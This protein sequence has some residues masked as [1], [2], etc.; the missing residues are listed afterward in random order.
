MKDFSFSSLSKIYL[1]EQNSALFIRTLRMKRQD[2][3]SSTSTKLC[4]MYFIVAQAFL[5]NT[6][7][8]EVAS[9]Y[10]CIRRILILN[11]RSFTNL[12]ACL[13]TLTEIESILVI[14]L[15]FFISSNCYNIE[16]L[17]LLWNNICA[18][19]T[20]AIIYC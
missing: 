8:N 2:F 12:F 11:C 4:F 17:L 9:H 7:Y 3:L 13:A 16:L 10:C 18:F 20:Q 1:E 6:I 5:L 19:I 15:F 14:F